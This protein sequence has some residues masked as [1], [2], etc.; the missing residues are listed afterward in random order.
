MTAGARDDGSAPFKTCPAGAPCIS[1]SSRRGRKVGGA[2]ADGSPIA[3]WVDEPAPEPG[4]PSAGCF[5]PNSRQGRQASPHA[6]GREMEHFVG[7][8]LSKDRL[9]VHLRPSAESFTVARNVE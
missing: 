9:D 6:Q 1:H 8:D 5:S 7:I 4:A 2:V 3:P